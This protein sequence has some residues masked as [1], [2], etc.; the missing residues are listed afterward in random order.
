[1]SRLGL[2]AMLLLFAFMATAGSASGQTPM[3]SPSS[4]AQRSYEN[5][6]AGAQAYFDDLWAVTNAYNERETTVWEDI[7][8]FLAYFRASNPPPILEEWTD[9]NIAIWALLTDVDFESAHLL[10]EYNDAKDAAEEELEDI[11]D[12]YEFT[13][14]F[15]G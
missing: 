3:A 10:Q 7:E 4:V 14:R 9:A 2:L 15:W 8:F 12:G 13:E 11:C 1:M 5:T 6:C